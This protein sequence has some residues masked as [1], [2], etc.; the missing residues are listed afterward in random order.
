MFKIVHP[1]S[2]KFK[3]LLYSFVAVKK[4]GDV[5]GENGLLKQAI[6]NACWVAL[7]NTQTLYLSAYD[8]TTIVEEFHK[9]EW[10][11]NKAYKYTLQY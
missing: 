5:I 3:D 7:T 4:K 10:M 8:Y 11:E 6:R 9:S 1:K 2:G